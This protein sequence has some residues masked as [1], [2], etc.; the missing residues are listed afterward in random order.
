MK[1]SFWKNRRVLITGGSG[2]IGSW[3]CKSLVSMQANVVVVDIKLPKEFSYTVSRINSGKPLFIRGDVRNF[4]SLQNIIRKYRVN[5]IFH[6]AAEAI[7]SRALMNPYKTLE[8]NIKGTWNVLEASRLSTTVK[9]IVVAS[10]DKAY[11]AAKVLPYTELTCLQGEAPYEVSKSCADLIC[12]AY[13]QSYNLPVCVTRCGN[14]YGGADYNFSR[15][16]PGTILSVLKNRKPIIRSDGNFVRDYIFIKDI[17][18]AYILVAERM[19]NKKIIGEVFNFGYNKPKT[20]LE[21]VQN[22]LRNM[23][24]SDLSPIILNQVSREIKNQY[25]NASKAHRLL[26]WKP[27]Y[28]FNRG[29]KQTIQWYKENINAIKDNK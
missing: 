24:R 2:F 17:V 5:T 1:K 10:S 19:N 16:I 29:L 25:L 6:L 26:K 15:I 4:T 7:V 27:K 20:V 22:I 9:R 23:R 12:Q 14:V 18:N 3:L 21:V 13:F 8:T 28:K 11:G